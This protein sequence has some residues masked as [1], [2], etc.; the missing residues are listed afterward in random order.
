M[1]SVNTNY[2]LGPGAGNSLYSP[3]AAGRT[4]CDCQGVGPIS[5]SRRTSVVLITSNA[6]YYYTTNAGESTLYSGRTLCSSGA[7][8]YQNFGNIE[9]G[10]MT[11]FTGQHTLTP[12]NVPTLIY[13]QVQ[14]DMLGL[15]GDSGAPYGDGPIWLGAHFGNLTCSGGSTCAAFSRASRVVLRLG[16]TLQNLGY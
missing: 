15:S 3:P 7:T 1:G 4:D 9:C 6:P 11:T 14:T 8:Y 13:D 2:A 5:S 10:Y 16:I 12:N